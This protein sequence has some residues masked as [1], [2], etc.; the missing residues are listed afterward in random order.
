[1]NFY[2]NLYTAD[3]VDNARI[4]EYLDEIR[5]DKQLTDEDQ[6]NL[7]APITIEELR[8]QAGRMTAQS[9]PGSDG[10]G[11][12]YLHL[13]FHIPVLTDLVIETYNDAF[14]GVFPKSWQDIRVRLL[15]KKGDLGL[16]KNWR[17]ISLIN[18]DAKI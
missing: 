9:S 15:P 5:F 7:M 1:S 11:Y 6:D 2:Q 3:T 13:L 14:R 8:V 10:S 18:C 4:T 17:P 16:L 12:A